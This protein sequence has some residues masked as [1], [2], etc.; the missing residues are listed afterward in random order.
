MRIIDRNTV[1]ENMSAT[2]SIQ[3]F[4]TLLKDSP[5]KLGLVAAM[6]PD[7]SV[8][9]LTQ[10]LKNVYTKGE[11]KDSFTPINALAIEWQIDVNYIKR[12]KVIAAASN[13][14]TVHIP[15][16]VI[17]AEKYF[18]RN[19]TF[20]AE[21]RQQYFV[22]KDADKV[23]GGWAY[24][25]LLVGN[26]PNKSGD[27]AYLAAGRSVRWRSNYFPE[28]SERG[29]T[30]FL[31]NTETHRNYISRNRGGSDWSA[32]YA[33]REEI[34]IADGKKG[35]EEI[36]RMNK[37]EKD[38][39][40]S[41]LFARENNMIFSETNF[42]INGKCLLQDD[43][44]RDIPMGDGILPQIEKVCDKFF[45]GNLTV[46]TIEDGM[47]AM[48]EKCDERIGNTWVFLVN[49]KFFNK[50]NKLMKND[51][52]FRSL[53]ESRFYSKG[54]GGMVKVGTS[55]SSYEFAGNTITF[56]VNKALSEEY[57]DRA[58]A[59]LVDVSK[60]QTSGRPN[61]AMFTLAGSELVTGNI[62]GLGGATGKESGD[63]QSSVHGSS[64]HIIGYSGAVLFNPY[65]SV[66]FEEA[67]AA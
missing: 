54:K 25:V 59:I 36:Y 67:I 52:R 9:M 30:K 66:I 50:F 16:T 40:D 51:L 22:V 15:A 20:A 34:F 31:S 12:V 10:A 48:S 5:E 32:D 44:G 38:C 64:Y 4:G 7:L 43:K 3:N 14:P 60:D 6:R 24:T 26:D 27:I 42:D 45:F 8:S 37:K 47:Q 2:R 23:S 53:D 41:F 57:F 61:L 56:M 29:Y 28:L 63:I 21:N 49:D 13:A 17:L 33:L 46:E 55:Y 62:N 58:Y 1:Y 19:D 11:K 18:D 39:M 65:K 35:K